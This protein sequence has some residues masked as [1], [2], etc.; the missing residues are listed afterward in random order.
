MA[1]FCFPLY[2]QQDNKFGIIGMDDDDTFI[3]YFKK[4]QNAVK[5]GDSAF[6]SYHV[7]YPLQIDM[8]SGEKLVLEKREDFQKHYNHIFNKRLRK[9]ILSQTIDSV[10][11]TAHAIMLRNGQILFNYVIDEEGNEEIILIRLS[12]KPTYSYY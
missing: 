12:Q 6:L 2:G 4:F 5:Y 10:D 1:L 9:T 11:V 3:E 7:D 8:E